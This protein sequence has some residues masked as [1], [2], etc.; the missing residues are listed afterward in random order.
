M[1]MQSIILHIN[2]HYTQ[3]LFGYYAKWRYNKNEQDIE[4][5]YLSFRQY[6]PT[7]IRA[8]KKPFGFVIQCSD[9]MLHVTVQSKGDSVSIG[10]KKRSVFENRG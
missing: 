6:I 9:G 1:D 8:T 10:Y 2:N 7:A 4:S 5:F 3:L